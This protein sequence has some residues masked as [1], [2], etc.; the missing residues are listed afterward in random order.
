NIDDG[1]DR[2]VVISDQKDWKKLKQTKQHYDKGEANLDE[3]VVT[4]DKKS[5]TQKGGLMIFGNIKRRIKTL[6]KG[7]YSDI[8]EWSNA[9]MDALN[10][11][12]EL[13]FDPIF[14]NQPSNSNNDERQ[15]EAEKPVKPVI[16]D[17]VKFHVHHFLNK[18]GK[19]I[20]TDTQKNPGYMKK[21]LLPVSLRKHIEKKHRG[22]DTVKF[23]HGV[24]EPL[25]EEDQN[26]N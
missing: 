20:K 19:V 1:S 11:L 4:A 13:I 2:K 14:K 21:K 23:K 6:I 24:V 10:L 18:Q 7:V 26:E 12:T 3:T 9:D 5:K 15:K 17:G 8:I 16:V 22:F 25:N